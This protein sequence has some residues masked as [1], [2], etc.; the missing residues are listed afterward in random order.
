[1][2]YATWSLGKHLKNSYCI[3]SRSIY[4]TWTHYLYFT[5]S[6]TDRC[7]NMNLTDIYFQRFYCHFFCRETCLNSNNPIIFFTFKGF[8]LQKI[9]NKHKLSPILYERLSF[10]VS[11]RIF[12][13]VK[14]LIFGWL[15]WLSLLPL[16]D[17]RSDNIKFFQWIEL[18][19]PTIP[20]N[21]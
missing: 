1:M 15:L 18:W 14:W 4:N 5:E 13:L 3:N 20:R 7:L 9:S 12:L 21:F 16:D 6:R 11:T 19:D 8:L 10:N 17:C 2:G